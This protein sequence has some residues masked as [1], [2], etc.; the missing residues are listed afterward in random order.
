MHI[1]LLSPSPAISLIAVNSMMNFLQNKQLAASLTVISNFILIL[2]KFLAGFLSGSISIISEAVHSCS[3]LL[4]AVITLVSVKKSEKP[5]DDDHQFGHG[6]YEDFSGL[7][8]GV[9]I[10]AAA[11]YIIWE[12]AQKLSGKVEPM[13]HPELAIGVMLISVLVNW[14]LCIYLFK[15]AKNTDSIALYADAEHLR[16]D[17]YSSFAVF[18]GLLAIKLTGCHFLDP[19]IALLVAAFIVNSGWKICRDSSDNLL[20]A[21]LPQADIEAIEEIIKGYEDIRDIKN[22]KTRKSGKD[23]EIVITLHVDG[24]K[25]IAFAHRLCDEV[26]SAVEKRLGNTSV[27][28]HIE[29]L[30]CEQPAQV[31]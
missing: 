13:S 19:V 30:N 11:A 21:S 23:K 8:Q 15:V 25:T 31:K 9:L 2:F 4:A 14:I 16:T 1:L 12:S 27:T 7:V 28:I 6:K 26:E 20:D 3:D 29:P 5:A 10:I 17:I 18:A 22:I 24:R